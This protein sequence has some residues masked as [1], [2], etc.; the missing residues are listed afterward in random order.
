MLL[1]NTWL[2]TYYEQFINEFT[3]LFREIKANW[4][5]TIIIEPKYI[6]CTKL[7][8]PVIK[9]LLKA[10]WSNSGFAT[11]K[12]REWKKE[13]NKKNNKLCRKKKYSEILARREK[14]VKIS[15]KSA[16]REGII[17]RKMVVYFIHTQLKFNYFANFSTI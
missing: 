13:K 12:E 14:L 7:K 8:S 9:I 10:I 3:C 16:W 4:H 5:T 11:M 6:P 17:L 1:K 15:I 2:R